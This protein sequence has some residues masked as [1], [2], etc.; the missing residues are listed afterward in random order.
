MWPGAENDRIFYLKYSIYFLFQKKTWIITTKKNIGL[1]NN[2][3]R[4]EK[5]AVPANVLVD[6]AGNVNFSSRC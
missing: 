1:H 4:H 3:K 2:W 6:I 5:I